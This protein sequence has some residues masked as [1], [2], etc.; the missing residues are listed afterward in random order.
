MKKIKHIYTELKTRTVGSHEL[1]SVYFKQFSATFLIKCVSVVLSVIYVPIVLGF[2]DQEKYGIWVTLTTVVN[3]IRLLDIGIGGGLQLKLSEAIALKQFQQGRIHVSTTYGIIGGIFLFLLIVFNLFNPLLNWQNILNSSII[4]QSEL[5]R[6]TSVTVSFV[7]V[8]FIL[9]TVSIV[10]LAHGDS[11][12]GS[13]IHLIIQILTLLLV[14]TASILADKGNLFLLAI[15]V[16]G[17]PVL[18]YGIVTTYTFLHK[19]PHLRPSFGLIKLRESRSLLTLSLQSFINSITFVI[20][21]G[22]IPFV[23]AQLFS[24]NEVAVFNVAYSLFS[25][26][27][28]IISLLVHPIK[29]LVTLAYTKKDYSW[30]RYMLKKLNM[31]SLLTVAGTIILILANQYI[32]HIWIGDKLEIPYILSVTLGIYTIINIL[33]YPYSIIINGTGKILITAILSPIN[34]GLFIT[35]SIFLSRALNN[36]AG[37]SIA[38]IFTCLVPLIVFPFWLRKVLSVQ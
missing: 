32:Y 20:I 16:T 35:L 23:V 15:I 37:V 17:I 21:Y 8:G 29:P 33:Q 10:Y 27:V 22:S 34:I 38:L 12:T 26:P 14:F 31:M 36:I 7:I 4:S 24:P 2:L 30:I 3:W 28:M 1:S 6:L 25:M 19:F 13:I 18:V 11:I 5:L 9:Q